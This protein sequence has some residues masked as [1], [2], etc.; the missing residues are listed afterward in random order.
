MNS[1]FPFMAAMRNVFEEN[2][3]TMTTKKEEAI[4]GVFMDWLNKDARL[5]PLPDLPKRISDLEPR[6]RRMAKNMRISFQDGK[7]VI[8]TD[9]E[10]GSLLSLLR[11]GS[12]WFDPHPDVNAAILL[13]LSTGSQV[14]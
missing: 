7:L 6:L 2:L 4:V 12:D 14:S 8:K 13:A 3:F 11:R 9:A 5:K 1:D 10:S